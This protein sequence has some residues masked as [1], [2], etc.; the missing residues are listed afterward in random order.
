MTT[1]TRNELSVSSPGPVKAPGTGG[2][3]SPLDVLVLSLWCGLA[4]GLLE[5][6]A[7]V[8]CRWIDPT[9]RL[10]GLSRHYVWLAPLSTFLIFSGV[11]LFLALLV[12]GSGPKG[13]DAKVNLGSFQPVELIKILIILFLAGYFAA[14]W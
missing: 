1:T 9:N 5:V 4:A 12:M 11:G 13:S 2:R 10:Y 6:G 14:N 3:F 8:L 7:R